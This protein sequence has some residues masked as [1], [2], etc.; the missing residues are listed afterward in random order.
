MK[1]RWGT[2]PPE[3]RK[4]SPLNETALLVSLHAHAGDWAGLH[5]E[6]LRDED[7][8]LLRDM[9]ERGL[10]EMVIQGGER[11]PWGWNTWVRVRS[12]CPTC[13][14]PVTATH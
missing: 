10:I 8:S 4:H 5:D 9:T 12:T 2:K 13:G 7:R 1:L 3:I 14:Q 11:D 6:N